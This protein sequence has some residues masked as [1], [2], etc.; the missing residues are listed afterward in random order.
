MDLAV[1]LLVLGSAA[2]HATW[3]AIVKSGG[4]P[5]L[6]MGVVI[7]TSGL[8][9][10]AL[11]PFVDFPSAETWTFILL[12]AAIQ[13]FYFIGIC[14]GYRFGD[15]SHVYPVQRGIAP[16]LVAIGAALFAGETLT[17]QG[18]VGVGIIGAAIISLAVATT[19]WPD[20]AKVLG[21]A[22][23]TGAMIAA[24]SVVNGMGGRTAA[25]FST[26]IVWLMAVGDTPFG[27]IAVAINWKRATGSVR[28]HLGLGAAGGLLTAAA[29]A[30]SIWA[31]TIAP[32][33]YVS[34]V[35]ETSVILAAWIGS[36]VLKEPF[37]AKR[38]AAAS[39]VV[40]GVVLLQTSGA[41]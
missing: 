11:I 29:Y 20:D 32:I 19:K 15:L 2:C 4:Q 34:A 5:W 38:I 24:Y 22:L 33:T 17:A 30:L 12:S 41:G 6:R 8:L 26:Y 1:L 40:L 16:F 31:M 14:L 10:C 35:R 37:G 18:M 36:R 21:F 39:F 25:H 3:N 28:R 13:Q 7:G 9:G 27:V 23:F